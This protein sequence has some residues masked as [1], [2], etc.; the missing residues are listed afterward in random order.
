ML[1][2][3]IDTTQ[4]DKIRPG[5]IKLSQGT[6]FRR[7]S[8]LAQTREVAAKG[9]LRGWLLHSVNPHSR[10]TPRLCLRRIAIIRTSS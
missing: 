4:R 9:R 7:N 10:K 3:K 6:E 2:S 1:S 5:I 8:S